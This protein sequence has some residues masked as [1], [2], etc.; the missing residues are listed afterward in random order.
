[1]SAVTIRRGLVALLA[2]LLAIGALAAS[3]AAAQPGPTLSVG[4]QSGL[5]RD[6]VTGSVFMPIYLSDPAPQ[7]VIVSYWT[8]DGT[9]TAGADYTR[10]GTPTSPRTVTIPA[11]ATQTQVNIPVLADDDT[12]PDETFS[13]VIGSATGGDVVIG[14]DTGTATIIDADALAGPNPVITVSNPT[15]IE[16]N[17]GQRRA[18][19]LIHLSRAPAS[20]VTVT[21]TTTDDTAVAGDDYAA[22]LPGAVVFAPG[23]ISKTI[24]VLV[25]SNTTLDGPRSFTLDVTVAGGSPIE[26]LNM[27]GTATITD[28]DTPTGPTTLA[29]AYTDVDGIAGYAEGVDV[30]IARLI[31][32]NGD[33]VPSAGDLIQT[34][35]FPKDPQRSGFGEF[36][37]KEWVVA[38]V[39]SADATVVRVTGA[40]G[41]FPPRFSWF[42][43]PN[44]DVYSEQ[45]WDLVDETFF[46]TDKVPPFSCPSSGNRLQIRRTQSNPDHLQST[47]LCQAPPNGALVTVEI[48]F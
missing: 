33:T 1:M 45:E 30:L 27:T 22:K 36:R 14:D 43:R 41:D 44:F 39:I 47:P 11:G 29:L 42:Q 3:P 32:S 37:V 28:D 31:D 19:F 34:D 25:N 10:W 8:L 26:E 20:P 17:T 13:L 9:A 16:G 18:Q 6:L 15:V 35:R 24:D 4:D 23:Q 40:R 38:S 2:P 7:P 12:E 5:E 46:R 48:N 21:Y